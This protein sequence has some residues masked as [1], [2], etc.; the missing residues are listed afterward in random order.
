[1]GI[2][3]LVTVFI[4]TYNHAKYIRECLDSILFQIVNFEYEILIHDDAS[5]DGTREILEEYKNKHPNLIKLLL[6]EKNRYSEGINKIIYERVIPF[7]RG[8]YITYTDGDDFWVDRKKLQKQFDYMES[9]NECSLCISNVVCINK[10]G[11]V[12]KDAYPLK[13]GIIS[14]KTV[15]NYPRGSFIASSSTFFRF[16]S[17]KKFERWRINYPVDDTPAFIQACFDG[18]IYKFK[19]KM[20]CYRR[21]SEGSWSSMMNDSNKRFVNCVKILNSLDMI[22]TTDL[23]LNSLIEIEKN[24]ATFKLAFY[25]KNFPVIFEKKN[26]QFFKE[27]RLKTR[28]LL[29]LEYKHNNIFRKIFG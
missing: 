9:H 18:Y 19:E 21:F 14:K 5:T 28:I 16:D 1:M 3:P 29:S 11:K 8:K 24:R 26:K 6:E 27:L 7:V 4:L 22:E 13:S 20:S 2:K 23:E 12:I 17:Y 15:I 10:E 25:E